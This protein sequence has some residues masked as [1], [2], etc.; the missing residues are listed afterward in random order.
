MFNLLIITNF[1]VNT[2]KMSHERFNWW[3]M[4]CILFDD[5]Y[6]ANTLVCCLMTIMMPANTRVISTWRTFFL[7]SIRY[8]TSQEIN[9]HLL[10]IFVFYFCH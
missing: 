10:N 5:N 7:V 2:E 1:G 8:N 9:S 4:L 6:D 3:S